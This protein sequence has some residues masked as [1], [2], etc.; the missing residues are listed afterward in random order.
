MGATLG[1]TPDGF[2]T[3]FGPIE[4]D[5][6]Y[7][8]TLAGQA[9][10]LNLTLQP[11]DDGEAH[12][13]L[14]DVV[15]ADLSVRWD[16]ATAQAIAG[17]LLPRDA[18]HVTDGQ[19]FNGYDHVYRSTLLAATF[20]ADYFYTD[21]GSV[22]VPPGTLHFE[23]FPQ[24]AGTSGYAQCVIEV[25]QAQVWGVPATPTTPPPPSAPTATP[26]QVPPTQGPP[27]PTP[28]PVA[29]QTL[30]VRGTVT[31]VT[32]NAN[33][34]PDANNTGTFVDYVPN[35]GGTYTCTVT[36][37]TA[38]SGAASS[39]NTLQVGMQVVASGTYQGGGSLSPTSHVNATT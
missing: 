12:A 36:S 23:C 35:G 34:T 14:I 6:D 30:T 28:L 3:H 33:V 37:S 31:S 8:S 29:G 27:M 24:P 10:L 17:A 38:W 19:A 1:G 26:M 25:G 32:P 9:V 21:Q 16:D 15:V 4:S 20:P 39:I 2:A 13:T 5:G 11:G 7:H 22:S 18:T